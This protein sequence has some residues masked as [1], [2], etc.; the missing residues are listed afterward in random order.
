MRQPHTLSGSRLGMGWRFVAVA[1]V[2]L[3]VGAPVMPASAQEIPTCAGRVA[4][5][6]GTEGSD[7]IEGTDDRDVIVGLGGDDALY[8]YRDDDRICGGDGNDIIHGYWGEDD[9][10][11]D[12]GDDRL[13]GAQKADT[14]RGGSGDDVI[15]GGA[16]C[17]SDAVIFDDA[18]NGVTVDLEAGT[19]EGHGS[20]RIR[21]A[22]IV[23]GTEFDDVLLG[24]DLHDYGRYQDFWGHDTFYGLGGNDFFDGR[25]GR[26]QVRFSFAP[27]SIHASLVSGIAVGEGTDRLVDITGLVGSDFDDVLIGD[28]RSNLLYGG[29]GDDELNGLGGRDL[30]IDSCECFF[31]DWMTEYEAEVDGSGSSGRLLGGEGNDMLLG[32]HYDNLLDGGPGADV[33]D[34]MRGDDAL[35]G[36]EGVD[37]VL[38]KGWWFSNFDWWLSSIRYD[39][40][41]EPRSSVTVDLSAGVSVGQGRDALSGIE[42]VTGSRFPD[43]LLGDD[44]PNRLLGVDADDVLRGGGGRDLL[45]G[46]Y[47]DRDVCVEGEEIRGCERS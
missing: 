8:G 6:V 36:G 25:E 37:R 41:L 19:A 18:P 7:T 3:A 43:V 39:T 22:E 16:N 27:S 42:E 33:L 13:Y 24:M 11:G 44:G 26:D 46:G 32:N 21:G 34:G 1:V 4:T 28:D 47:G 38:Y 5:I 17:Y 40:R 45:R 12:A 15:D 20:D 9:L 23:I 2:I 30:V 14:L 29:E 10:W 35:I 31:K